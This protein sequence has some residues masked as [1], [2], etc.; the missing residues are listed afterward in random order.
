MSFW[1]SLP[2]GFIT[3]SSM[4]VCYLLEILEARVALPMKLI[5]FISRAASCI[6]S[7]WDFKHANL[8]KVGK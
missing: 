1:G 4:M 6:V 8:I 2:V 3:Q 7:T 5:E